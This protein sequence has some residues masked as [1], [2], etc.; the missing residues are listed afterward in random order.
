M[1]DQDPDVVLPGWIPAGFC[2]YVEMSAPRLLV[3]VRVKSNS[4]SGHDYGDGGGTDDSSEDNGTFT[5]YFDLVFHRNVKSYLV[6][7]TGP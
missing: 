7:C 5:V 6:S 1:R 3:E 2:G 4:A